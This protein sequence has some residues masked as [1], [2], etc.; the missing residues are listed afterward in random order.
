MQEQTLQLKGMC[1]FGRL[2]VNKTNKTVVV[3]ILKLKLGK[4]LNIKHLKPQLNH[5]S[6][7]KNHNFQIK[8]SINPPPNKIHYPIS[9]KIQWK[10]IK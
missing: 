1:F 7:A 2:V 10:N 8:D 6:I 9:V 5:F 4:V 3:N